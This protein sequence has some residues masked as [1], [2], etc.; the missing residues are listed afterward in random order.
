M[1]K[2][3]FTL[4]E[5]LDEAALQRRVT[6]EATQA[7]PKK[8]ETLFPEPIQTQE[9]RE[10][11]DAKR[12][13]VAGKVEEAK[14][15]LVQLFEPK[16]TDE[17]QLVSDEPEVSEKTQTP[18]VAP[19]PVEVEASTLR[20]SAKKI[21]KKVL[22]F[23]TE[24]LQEV[25]G[26]PKSEKGDLKEAVEE[27]ADSK[28]HL[29]EELDDLHTV[30]DFGEGVLERNTTIVIERT[31]AKEKEPAPAFAIAQLAIL[32]LAGAG[33]FM[34]SVGGGRS[35]QQRELQT[36]RKTAQETIHQ[37][38][39]LQ[40]Q[41]A[42]EKQILIEQTQELQTLQQQNFEEM[43][44]K[45]QVAFV[46]EV[47]EV[48]EHQAQV[49]HEVTEQLRQPAA[50][51]AT[52]NALKTERVE[53]EAPASIE[54]QPEAQHAARPQEQNA[55]NAGAGSATTTPTYSARHSN[56]TMLQKALQEQHT[57]Q[58]PKKKDIKSAWL[59]TVAFTTAAIVAVG[60]L[61]IQLV[62]NG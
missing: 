50:V 4:P 34:A 51:E 40:Q 22:I 58:T 11:A 23:A 16:E 36:S 33:I 30:S 49:T 7:T 35:S 27:L 19:A 61:A 56:A 10:K 21:G 3:L 47:S 28:H 46:R 48:T 8:Q 55:M 38:E 12:D 14:S 57:I 17:K 9:K 18:E 32:A 31:V 29:K 54:S 62:I 5:G 2:N 37:N 39:Q 15:E 53:A 44:H 60:W 25:A 42:E 20:E 52:S 6:N 59:F 43:H 41:L 1:E 24:V 13:T 26:L 45:E